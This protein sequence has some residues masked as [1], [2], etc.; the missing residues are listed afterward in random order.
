MKLSTATV[1]LLVFVLLFGLFYLSY[2]TLEDENSYNISMNVN[3]SNMVSSLDNLS[4]VSNINK[5][6]ASIY[7]LRTSSGSAADILGALASAGIG[8]LKSVGSLLIFPFEIGS[9]LQENYNI[10]SII[11]TI[12]ILIIVILVGFKLLAAYIGQGDI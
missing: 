11:T 6:A 3:E 5:T 10:P 4:I 12:V 1:S 8:A 7:T 2:Q 9:I